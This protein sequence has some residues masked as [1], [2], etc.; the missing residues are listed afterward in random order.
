MTGQPGPTGGSAATTA[1]LGEPRRIA[2]DVFRYLLRAARERA[3]PVRDVEKY[4]EVLWLARVPED[5]ACDVYTKRAADR[6]PDGPWLRVKRPQPREEPPF[7]PE[8]L[9]PWLPAERLE[10][11][12][13]IPS[14]SEEIEVPDSSEPSGVRL[15]RWAD[16]GHLER[17]YEEYVDTRWTPWAEQEQQRRPLREI[18]AKLH[19]AWLEIEKRSEEVELLLGCGLLTWWSERGYTTRRHLVTCRATVTL[20]PKNGRLEVGPAEDGS[21]PVLE[22]DML[23]PEDRPH[24]QAATESREAIETL[25]PFLMLPREVGERLG[26]WLGSLNAAA[27][28]HSDDAP[29]ASD[30]RSPLVTFA[31]AIILRRRSQRS[32]VQM[33]ERVLE[34]L[35]DDAPLPKPLQP[36][37]DPR[38]DDG[39]GGEDFA[40]NLEV[41][42]DPDGP[43]LPLPSNQEQ[44]RIVE[45]LAK[46][47]GVLVQGPPGT[48]KSHTIANLLCHLLAA[49]Q[50]VLVTS[51]GPRALRVLMEK[52]PEEIRPLC[53]SVLGADKGSRDQL[54]RAVQ[55]IISKQASWDADEADQDVR[56]ARD[57][58]RQTQ[59]E[60]ALLKRRVIEVLEKDTF[61]QSVGGGLYVGTAMQIAQRVE[62]EK[63]RYG[64]L[65]DDVAEDTEPSAV[66]ADIAQLWDL[67]SKT[68]HKSGDLDRPRVRLD[69]IP[70]DA[71]FRAIC[72]DIASKQKS[73]D[74]LKDAETHD[75]CRFVVRV[76]N[77]VLTKL[78]TQLAGQVRLIGELGQAPWAMRAST[79]I[80]AGQSAYWAH[81]KESGTAL[82]DLA[83]A[84][85]RIGNTSLAL[86]EG[87]SPE[88]AWADLPLL[89]TYVSSG[90]WRRL[91]Q[92]TFGAHARSVRELLNAKVGHDRCDDMSRVAVLREMLRVELGLSDIAREWEPL[93]G[94]LQG[95][96]PSRGAA[97]LDASRLL[98]RAFDYAQAAA[99][100]GQL[101]ADVDCPILPRWNDK[102][103]LMAF[104]RVCDCVS[105]VRDLERA[106]TQLA[107]VLT[108]ID[109]ISRE[110]NPHPVSEDLAAA[111]R[112]RDVDAYSR[113]Y[114]A[115]ADLDALHRLARAVQPAYPTLY[116][117]LTR[118][119]TDTVW[120][121]R[122]SSFEA[123]FRWAQARTWL[124]A[125]LQEASD[126]NLSKK[127]RDQQ[128]RAR[129]LT[130]ELAAKRAWRSCL[131]RLTEPQR[132]ALVAWKAAWSRK[133][134]GTGKSAGRHIQAARKH[135]DECRSAIPAWIMPLHSVVET[136][137]P[138]AGIFDV[139]IVDEAS[140]CGPDSLF[141]L[142]IA[143]KVLV[144]G[145]D[146]QISPEQVGLEDSVITALQSEELARVP[147]R[148]RTALDLRAS[149]FSVADYAYRDR[150]VLRE[151][152]R[153]MPEIIGFSNELCY[154]PLGCALEPL[155]H[156]ASDRLPPIRV[157]HV[158]GGYREG[159]ARDPIN[160]EEARA[161]VEKLLECHRSPEYLGKS[162][163]VISLLGER[164]AREVE[165]LLR[166]Q[167]GPEAYEH[168]HLRCGDAYHFQGDERDVMFI[169]M[170]A[171]PGETQLT[172]QTADRYR[173]RYNVAFSR[174]RD[175]VWLFHTAT[176][177]DIP[178]AECMRRR[179]LEYCQRVLVQPGSISG[180][181]V[182]ELATRPRE[183][184]APA[185]FRS[186][187]EVDVALDISRRG[188]RVLPAYT[189]G[190][191]EVDLVIEGPKGNRVAVE[192]D[193]DQF[194]P[195][196][197]FEQ[198]L[199]RERILT[200]TGLVFH[201]VRA[202]C[203]Y[204]SRAAALEPLWHLL[205]ELG[206]RPAAVGERRPT[207]GSP[208]DATRE[209]I[210]LHVDLSDGS[211]G[212]PMEDDD[213]RPRWARLTDLEWREAILKMLSGCPNTSCPKH[214][215]TTRVLRLLRIRTHGEP[216]KECDRRTMAALEGLIA[217][218]RVE[219]YTA[220]N[221]RV[222]LR[223]E[224]RW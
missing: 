62:H 214:S 189:V 25:D 128:E 130:A 110:G 132:Q 201:R 23:D 91:L 131:A 112:A 200:R 90:P 46:R 126:E 32:L 14:P 12:N 47:P 122:L 167:L 170:V 41:P 114:A 162:F 212:A 4:E 203:Y 140:Q 71:G 89:E 144:V 28:Y 120:E 127:L 117:D 67:L 86:P 75:A 178:N 207:F 26:G 179:L 99:Q 2:R 87:I 206:I 1:D 177:N 58:L 107:G 49:G 195:P 76:D 176:V 27:R 186:W 196:E 33:Y 154:R 34:Q 29:P 210:P 21:R 9:R 185:P 219:E 191:Y 209:D 187:F 180:F 72:C 3:T 197:Q 199:M 11:P 104:V 175:Q 74:A 161:L 100:V 139:V 142:Y 192:C 141:L 166:D 182:G 63:P 108:A 105:A 35:S 134:K 54:E 81:L 109:S 19:T 137:K 51:Q 43:F 216:R 155:R 84:A 164:Q 173:Q 213:D 24:S 96:L 202:S 95:S 184:D 118:T 15:V 53:V 8:E 78:R 39:A 38:V 65:A 198:D 171:A 157:Q 136:I 13:D 31:P 93:I 111:V 145:D 208:A 66:S 77:A 73:Y 169:S 44:E 113:A 102:S 121:D 10:D 106:Q 59:S 133:G 168:R 103:D 190:Q 69:T 37:V 36:L 17:A 45:R 204:R 218:A 138:G 174:A 42:N 98:G 151:H 64:W 79:E 146:Q 6:D 18:Y 83:E 211:R 80:A 205:E 101:L 119:F 60:E 22:E 193:G 50:R 223:R 220:T 97:L 153:C 88:A 147:E 188:F 129:E 7:P 85:K 48:G 56:S 124:D 68:C 82:K 217:D 222:R 116:A 224:K 61:E 30:S 5:D 94:P 181:D 152:F 143:R 215:V 135:L 149:L 194:H 172:A 150:V 125:F 183:G 40:D 160:R 148:L 52:L 16:F 115:L 165:R 57:L 158:R 221:V 159:G 55:G 163:G 156:Y 70:D 92:R 123:A 20:D